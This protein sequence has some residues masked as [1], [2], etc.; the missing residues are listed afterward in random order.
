MAMWNG[1][2]TRTTCIS[3]RRSIGTVVT[4]EFARNAASSHHARAV[5][6]GQGF[7][8]KQFVRPAVVPDRMYG[9]AGM[10]ESES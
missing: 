10:A 9:A 6:K 3:C 1:A 8:W 2:A 4:W 5:E 7:A